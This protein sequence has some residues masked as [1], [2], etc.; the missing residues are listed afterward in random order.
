MFWKSKETKLEAELSGLKLR[1]LELESQLSILKTQMNSLRGLINRKVGVENKLRGIDD[2]DN[3]SYDE[4]EVR[5]AFGGELP[6]ELV[7]DE[8]NK[9]RESQE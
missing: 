6:F 5:K 8:M 3:S 2:D 7:R 9:K 1:Y 4:E